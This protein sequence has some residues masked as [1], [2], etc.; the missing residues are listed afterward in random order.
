MTQGDGHVLMSFS[1]RTDEQKRKSN[2]RGLNGKDDE[3]DVDQMERFI[4]MVQWGDVPKPMGWEEGDAERV[5]DAPTPTPASGEVEDV[6]ELAKRLGAVD[7]TES[8]L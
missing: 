7:V 3:E 2:K 6:L 4:N 1:D 8:Q 5:E